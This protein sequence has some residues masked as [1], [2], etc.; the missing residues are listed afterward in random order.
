MERGRGECSSDWPCFQ[1]EFELTDVRASAAQ[2]PI[3][4]LA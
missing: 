4:Y 1:F 2:T 3:L